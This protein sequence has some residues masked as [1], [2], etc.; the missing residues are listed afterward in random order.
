[1][2]LMQAPLAPHI[3][4]ELW[5]KLGH[6]GTIT[7]Q[8]FPTA[9]AAFLVADTVEYPVQVNGKVRSRITVASNTPNDVVQAAAL[10]D[11][12]VLAA[13]AGATPKKLIVVA[14]RMVNIVI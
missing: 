10:A 9:D 12:K 2:V 13:L 6:T 3:A 1:V 5:A 8:P 7:Y 4:E 11:T 14:G